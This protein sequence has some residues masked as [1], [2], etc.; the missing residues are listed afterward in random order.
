MVVFAPHNVVSIVYG[1]HDVAA[2]LA[3]VLLR[4]TS[5]RLHALLLAA[6][7]NSDIGGWN[8]PFF[9]VEY[10]CCGLKS[11][12]CEVKSGHCDK[13]GIAGREMIVK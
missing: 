1:D 11:C 8:L 6:T 4:H 9:E 7:C 5:C 2:H 3:R 13:F 12:C 10:C